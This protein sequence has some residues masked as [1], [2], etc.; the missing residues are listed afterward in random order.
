MRLF[1]SILAEDL[2]KRKWLAVCVTLLFSIPLI[3]FS[4]YG[5]GD[6]GIALFVLIPTFI[7]MCSTIVLGYGNEIT[8]TQARHIGFLCLFILSLGLL[9]F[10]IEGVICMVMASP[11][12]IILT[13]L[14]TLMGHGLVR[15]RK[16]Q[17]LY[18]IAF[19]VVLIPL[20]GIYGKRKIPPVEPVVSKIVIDADIELNLRSLMNFYL[21]QVYRIP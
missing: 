6:Y 13:W 12:A 10:A 18:S 4:I 15:K 21:K 2:K 1:E 14:G 16:D 9:V 19:F 20:S 17:A 8:S 5:L 7:G 3:L 11:F